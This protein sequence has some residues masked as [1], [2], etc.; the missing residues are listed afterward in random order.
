MQHSEQ[1]GDLAL[2][3]SS[4]QAIIKAPTKGKTASLGTYSYKY[5]D[6][7]DVIDCYREPLSKHG[8]AIAQTMRLEDGHIILATRLLHK[9]GQWLE[10]DYPVTA[11]SKPQEQGSAI[12]YA[13]R[14]AVTALLGIAAEDDDDG[15]AAQAGESKARA[16][17]PAP[18]SPDAGAILDLAME[19][20]LIRGGTM[21]DIIR[22]A[23]SFV[24]DDGKEKF[25]TDPTKVKPGKWLTGT[26]ERL[27][28]GLAKLRAEEPGAAEGA[29]ILK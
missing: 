22:K 12:T 28:R 3:L 26:R 8:L 6:L 16:V 10:S 18:P 15:A 11:Y 19:V 27:E 2:A 29:A 7:A 1:I 17:E 14:Y 21:D 23:S 5:A 20:Q 9:S 4:A 25:F 24:G 13:R